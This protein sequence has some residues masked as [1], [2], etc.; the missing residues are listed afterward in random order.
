MK[1]AFGVVQREAF[2]FKSDLYGDGNAASGIA[3]HIAAK[4]LV[5]HPAPESA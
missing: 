4:G 5:T 1:I 2:F 3:E